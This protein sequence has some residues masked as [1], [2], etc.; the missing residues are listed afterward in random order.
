[1]NGRCRRGD[2]VRAALVFVIATL[3]SAVAW[4][5][6]RTDVITLRNG[7]RITGEIMELDRGR[8]EL[9]TDDAGTIDIEWDKITR[10][11]AV[12]QFEVGTS[13]GR[14]FLGS[15]QSTG[16]LRV[17]VAGDAGPVMLAMS[18]VTGIVPIGTS[19]WARLDG[20]FDAGFNYTRSSGIAQTTINTITFFRRPSFVFRLAA[21][22]TLTHRTDENKRDDQGVV[23][24][25]YARYRGRRLFVAGAGRLESNESLGLVLRSQVG[26][27]VGARLVNTN[28][29]QFEVSGGV[30][31]NQE[32]GVDAD[33]TRNVEGVLGVKWSYY[34]YEHP[35]TNVDGGVEYYPSLSAWGRQRL[36]VN[37]AIKREMWKDFFVGF[38]GYY[39]LDTDP[40][41]PT[42][43]R[44]DLGLTLSVGWSY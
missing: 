28:R 30:V 9:K 29:G 2:R 27:F 44:A 6:G 11:E 42:A 24:F 12:R 20:S 25:S 7:D 17:V 5:Q 35:K 8:L 23:D 13:D 40:P 14:R 3:S 19:F 38:N 43:A 31:G 26:G 4:G 33:A 39:S 10:I 34:T 36:Q 32:Q 21:S 22:S 41:N 37:S 16:D 18:E 1:V 15:L